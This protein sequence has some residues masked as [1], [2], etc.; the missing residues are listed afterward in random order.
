M[1][2]REN[3]EKMAGANR[4]AAGA[5]ETGMSVKTDLLDD[6][7]VVQTRDVMGEISMTLA[8]VAS[9]QME[10]AVREQLIRLGWT[11]PGGGVPRFNGVDCSYTG[12]V[13]LLED[14]GAV[15][16]GDLFYVGGGYMLIQWMVHSLKY[17]KWADNGAL[18]WDG[19]PITH[20][21]RSTN[22]GYHHTGRGVTVVSNRN[23]TTTEAARK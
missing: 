15:V 18:V 12:A 22:G 14:Y 2:H 9:A 7:R 5:L 13:V 3:L 17:A 20:K 21:V 16:V 19:C 23:I 1:G 11:P 4:R 8:D 6:G 10:A